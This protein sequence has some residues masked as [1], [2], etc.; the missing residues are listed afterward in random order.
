MANGT[1]WRQTPVEGMGLG[2]Y[3]VIRGFNFMEVGGMGQERVIW[4]EVK[5]WRLGGSKAVV[6]IIT[7]SD[8]PSIL[9]TLFGQEVGGRTRD[10][11]KCCSLGWTW[12]GYGSRTHLPLRNQGEYKEE[13]VKRI[14]RK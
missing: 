12:C 5:Y 1:E 11:V 2:D 13:R 9:G 14:K 6:A 3:S 4:K 7:D 10:T 8:R